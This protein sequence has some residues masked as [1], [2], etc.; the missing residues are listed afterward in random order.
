MDKEDFYELMVRFIKHTKEYAPDSYDWV[1]D[2]MEEDDMFNVNGKDLK[3][4][5]EEMLNV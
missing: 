3:E 1:I 5:F 4:E 2:D